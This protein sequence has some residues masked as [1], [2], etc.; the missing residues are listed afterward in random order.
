MSTYY[1]LVYTMGQQPHR[2]QYMAPATVAM[3]W[4][5]LTHVERSSPGLAAVGPLDGVGCSQG[6][7]SGAALGKLLP[8]PELFLYNVSVLLRQ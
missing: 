7:I 4:E 8:L 1:V 3:M 5:V 2:S 6:Q